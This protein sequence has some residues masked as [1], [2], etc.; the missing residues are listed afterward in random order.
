MLLNVPTLACLITPESFAA[1]SVVQCLGCARI[2]QDLRTRTKGYHLRHS[3][4][5]CH[6]SWGLGRC[7]RLDIHAEAKKMPSILVLWM[8]WL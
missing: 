4:L 7:S 1:Q 3:T 8:T 5:D 2:L 6:A